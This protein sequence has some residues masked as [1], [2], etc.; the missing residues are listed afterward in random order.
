MRGRRRRRE[1]VRGGGEKT[2]GKVR[3]EDK[4]ESEGGGERTR[5][6]VRGEGRRQGA[7]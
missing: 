1:K 3:G 4:R 7:K 6:K 2:R 5:E